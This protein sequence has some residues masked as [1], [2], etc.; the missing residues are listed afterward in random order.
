MES[1]VLE[2]GVPAVTR[3]TP[4]PQG[5][6]NVNVPF[7]ATVTGA[8]PYTYYWTFCLFASPQTSTDRIPGVTFSRP[9]VGNGTVQVTNRF[10]SSATFPFTIDIRSVMAPVI[11]TIYPS[12]AEGDEGT[13]VTFSAEARGVPT[14]YSW[15]FGGGAEPN[16]S[17]DPAPT[18]TL[19]NPGPPYEAT[20]T[21]SNDQGQDEMSFTLTV[22]GWA[23]TPVDTSGTV[24]VSISLAH[25][26]SG[27]DG[28]SYQT[29]GKNLRYARRLN[30]QW[31]TEDVN[32]YE[33]DVL[34]GVQ[35]RVGVNNSLAFNPSPM[36]P[37]VAEPAIAYEYAQYNWDGQ[38]WNEVAIG[39]L[40]YAHYSFGAW[41][42]QSDIVLN[43]PQADPSLAFIGS[44]PYASY[45]KDFVDD[46]LCLA[47]E[48]V[49]PPWNITIVDDGPLPS[50][51]GQYSSLTTDSSGNWYI[52]YQAV[53]ATIPQLRLARQTYMAGLPIVV[54]S[55]ISNDGHPYLAVDNSIALAPDNKV[56]I[57]YLGAQYYNA[58]MLKVARE[59]LDSGPW[60]F[61]LIELESGYPDSP[62]LDIT[63][64]GKAGLAYCLHWLGSG[65]ALKYVE[66]LNGV[67]E[68]PETF[69]VDATACSLAFTP[70]GKPSIAY[71]ADGNLYYTELF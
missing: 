38:H 52:A 69:N 12:P 44:L 20:L 6:P 48:T 2:L 63:S 29:C 27:E 33:E 34:N 40:R 47:H 32:L 54:D 26:A 1:D 42:I 65:R 36:V 43:A 70:G 28:I 18:V 11:D 7:R 22:H 30:S 59:P 17:S 71:V 57:A 41:S 25:D 39:G 14:S 51:T 24:N 49:Q 64:D 13:Q 62:S 68:S 67:W 66:N 9:T 3:V 15:N 21:V 5:T 23:I 16:T 46:D 55:L 61:K 58:P 56:W 4:P 19:A 8:S 53:Q 60:E 45:H 37:S 31:T 50:G 35:I 10:G